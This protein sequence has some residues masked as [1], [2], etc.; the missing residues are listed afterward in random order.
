MSGDFTISATSRADSGKGASRRLRR[1][2]NK[3]PG[4]VY[5]AD[6][7]AQQIAIEFKVLV[8]ALENEA[9]YS[10]VLTLDVDGTA[11]QV[12]LK[13]LQRHPSKSHPT[14]ADFQRVDTTH[15][16]HMQ[17]PLH[18][19]N[20]DKCAGV[21]QHGGTIAH[22]MS[23]VEVVCLAKDLPEFIE[24]DMGD[25][26]IGT[27]IHL[28]NLVLPAGVELKELQLGDDHDQPVVSVN[29]PRGGAA[30]E[31]EEGGAADDAE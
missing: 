28:S 22:Q 17:V 3:V 11:E 7:P 15:K 21:K 16:L 2:E 5:G 19:I 10:H 31:E 25:A 27:V 26:E 24:V 29:A 4:I 20:E 14:H 6:K 1:L 13:D 23:E 30:D 8:K 12:V 9:F 18:F